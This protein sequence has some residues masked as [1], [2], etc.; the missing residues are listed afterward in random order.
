MKLHAH[1]FHTRYIFYLIVTTFLSLFIVMGCAGSRSR[2]TAPSVKYPISLSPA[3]RNI[4][5]TIFKEDDLVKVGKF[6]YKYI[7]VFM[8]WTAIPL[9]HIKHDISNAVNEQ[10][11]KAGGDAIIN[12]T[13]KNEGDGLAGFT[14]IISLGLLPSSSSIEIKGDI[15]SRKTNPK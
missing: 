8:L 14:S 10:I 3:I 4:D 6:Y 13:V 9:S 15:V 11:E 1:Y 5:G 12:L 7:T 2:I